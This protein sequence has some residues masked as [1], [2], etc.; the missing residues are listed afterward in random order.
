M[1][2]VG[3]WCHQKGIDL[4]ADV[5]EWL[6]TTVRL[7]WLKLTTQM[8][9]T[10]VTRPD[11]METNPAHT[12]ATS[13]RPGGA[14]IPSFPL[15]PAP[16][17]AR[18]PFPLSAFLVPQPLSELPLPRS[19]SLCVCAAGGAAQVSDGR[20]GAHCRQPRHVRAQQAQAPAGK[21][22]GGVGVWVDRRCVDWQEVC[23][24]TAPDTRNC[25]G[26]NTQCRTPPHTHTRGV[27][28]KQ[29]CTLQ[30]PRSG[31]SLRGHQS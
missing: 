4:I 20:G 31:C 17:T 21:L 8:P 27:V 26:P 9:P 5:A 1:V 2:F 25:R 22:G 24:G 14:G 19:L 12:Y 6:L 13:A 30:T 28:V 23:G 29:G 16:R 15:C 10:R 18:V 7:S 3:R 11:D